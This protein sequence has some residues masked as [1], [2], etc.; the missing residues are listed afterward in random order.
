MET[1]KKNSKGHFV[2]HGFNKSKEYEFH[3]VEDGDQSGFVDKAPLIK[4]RREMTRHEIM[5]A[6]YLVKLE[7]YAALQHDRLQCA[8]LL[9]WRT[10]RDGRGRQPVLV[11][12]RQALL[13][14]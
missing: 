7:E 11:T 8:E 1:Y 3:F 5:N 6:Y 12:L 9:Y 13:C 14:R 10:D 4:I 2:K